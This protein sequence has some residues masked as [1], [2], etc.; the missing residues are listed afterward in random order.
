VGAAA[1][2]QAPAQVRRAVLGRVD[3]DQAAYA[4]LLVDGNEAALVETRTGE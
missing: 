3:V 1:G 2:E 4:T